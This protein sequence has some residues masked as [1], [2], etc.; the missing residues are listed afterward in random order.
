MISFGKIQ[1][2]V[3]LQLT[4]SVAILEVNIRRTSCPSFQFAFVYSNVHYLPLKRAPS[5]FFTQKLRP[6]CSLSGYNMVLTNWFVL[7]NTQSF[8]L[9]GIFPSV[10]F[11]VGVYR[12]FKFSSFLL[13][14][15]KFPVFS[16]LGINFIHSLLR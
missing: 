4:Y 9:S 15:T 6:I 1:L 14:F 16:A 7:R 13:L 12:Y 10:P 8:F 5:P 2:L 11:L 3:Y